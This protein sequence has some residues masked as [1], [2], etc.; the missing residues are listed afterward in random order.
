VGFH[1]ELM[2]FCYCS[3]GGRGLGMGDWFSLVNS[4]V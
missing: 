4:Y 1:F 2:L 3:P